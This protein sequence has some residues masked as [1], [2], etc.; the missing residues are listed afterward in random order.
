MCNAHGSLVSRPSIR[1]K[2]AGPT[3][4][5]QHE[6]M[7]LRRQRADPNKSAT[8][9]RNP[10]SRRAIVMILP[11]ALLAGATKAEAAATRRAKR[12]KERILATG[13]VLW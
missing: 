6:S 7:V 2:V 5:P 8:H 10:R 9:N 12:K 11:T 4:E 13:L 1:L 3:L